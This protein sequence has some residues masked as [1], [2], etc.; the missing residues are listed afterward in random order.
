MP[1]LTL[2]AALLLLGKEDMPW[3]SPTWQSITKI[4]GE[5]WAVAEN[6]ANDSPTLHIPE[7]TTKVANQVKTFAMTV[8]GLPSTKQEAYVAKRSTDNDSAG[9]TAWATFISKRSAQWGINKIIDDILV[10]AGRSPAQVLRDMNTRE[11]PFADIAQVYELMGVVAQK[12]FGNEAYIGITRDVHMMDLLFEMVTEQWKVFSAEGASPKPSAIKVFLKD[13]HKLLTLYIRYDDAEWRARVEQYMTDMV[14]MLK[15]VR[16]E[17]GSENTDKLPKSLRDAL[18]NLATEE[19]IYAVTQYLLAMIE[20]MDA[21]ATDE[22]VELDL[23]APIDPAW[24]EGIESLSKITEDA[25]WQKLGFTDKKIPF[26]QR[27]T[28]PDGLI[29]PWS[30]EGQAWLN[31]ATSKRQIYHMLERTFE[32]KPVLLMDG[33]GLGKTLQVLGTIACLAYYSRM[34]T[35]KGTFPG[36]FAGRKMNTL[37]SNIPDLPHIID[38]VDRTVC[39]QQAALASA[40]YLGHSNASSAWVN[41]PYDSRPFRTM[42]WQCSIVK[43]SRRRLVMRCQHNG[44][45]RAFRGLRERATALIAMTATPITTKAQASSSESHTQYR[46]INCYRWQDL[47]IMG[48]WMGVPNFNDYK[49]FLE[50]NKE[51]NWANRQ[52]SK[53]LRE[54][55]IE[56]NI[57]PVMHDW[58]IKMRERFAPHVI[59][60][61][62]DSVD[63]SGNKLFGLRPYQEHTMKLQMYEWEMGALRTFA[64]DLVKENPIASADMRKVSDCTVV[65]PQLLQWPS[66]DYRA[67][68]YGTKQHPGDEWPSK[69][70]NVAL[71][72]GGH[73]TGVMAL[74]ER[75]MLH[76]M[77]NPKNGGHWK[78]PASLEAWR[79]TEKTIKLDTLAQVVHHHLQSNGRA[80]LAMDDDGKCLSPAPNAVDDTADYGEDDRIVIYSAFPSSNQAIIDVHIPPSIAHLS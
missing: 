20:E 24:T 72:R 19:D 55:G 61:T 42:P 73:Q 60:R 45:H 11:L 5:P 32:G 14:E 12:L 68:L 52:D 8:W 69:M 62:I 49:E 47:Y 79:S 59:H 39:C 38:L 17:P 28:D 56:G 9:R 77:L 58:M 65:A 35:E 71:A 66:A 29:D 46:I 3:G 26:F 43:Q 13:L 53:A 1:S 6:A 78:K 76:P 25:L 36:D 75:S 57:I 34:Y 64:K 50:L 51:I 33:V 44:I 10:G 80:P 31:T 4:H 2:T 30:Q 23:D 16:K 7:W 48:Q 63:H 41:I 15:V 40:H 21:T 54:A 74:R 37:D 70:A 22:Q 18:C 67:W 27:W